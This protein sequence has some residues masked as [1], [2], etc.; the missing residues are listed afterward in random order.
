MNL[1]NNIWST[2]EGGYK[3]TYDA[4]IP[5]RQLQSTSD[6][7]IIET[8]FA[9]LWGNLHHQGDVG[10]ASY[11]SLPHIVST[12]IDKKSLDWNYVGLCVVIEHCRLSGHNPE[13]P[14]EYKTEY[15]D[16][17]KKLEQYLL[18]N[19]KSITDPDTL[20]LTLALFATANGQAN[21]GR[22]I[23]NLDEDVIQEFLEQF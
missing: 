6:Q 21:L 15:I 20:R 11:L 9:E 1:D 10:L 12:C 19:F 17:L 14:R 18:S 22:A 3:I 16:A 2:L 4:S 23:E 7:T 5:L 13:L 8:V